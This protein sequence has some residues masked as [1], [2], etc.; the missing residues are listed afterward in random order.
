MFGIGKKR[1]KSKFEFNSDHELAEEHTLIKRYLAEAFERTNRYYVEVPFKDT[2]AGV[3]IAK[4][5]PELLCNLVMAAY[6]RI[7]CTE[8]AYRQLQEQRA[9]YSTAEPVY[10]TRSALFYMQRTLLRRKLPFTGLQL[11]VLLS[12]LDDTLDHESSYY[13]FPASGIIK[14]LKDFVERG[15]D[16]SE[17]VES[18][19]SI[20]RKA[21]KSPIRDVQKFADRVLTIIG[22]A[23]ELP[24]RAGE[25]WADAAFEYVE[26]AAKDDKANWGALLGHCSKV[27]GGKPNKKWTND[28]ERLAN[29]VTTDSIAKV[30]PDWFLLVDRP[31]TQP[32]REWSQWAPDPNLLIDDANADVL[33]GLAWV[34]GIVGDD[35]LAD[36][37][38][39]L[40][41]SAYR[42]VPGVGPRATKVG[43]ACVWAL[44][45]IP[46][47]S[48]LAALAILKVRVKYKPAQ[49]GIA[50]ALAAAAERAG[51]TPEELEEIGVPAYGMEQVGVRRETL[52]EYEAILQVINAKK[53]SLTWEN[54]AGKTIKTVPK[55]VR[56]NHAEELKDL[57]QASKDISKMLSA[58]RDRLDGLFL[59]ERSWK[60]KDWLERYIQHPLVGTLGQRLI[61]KFEGIDDN[62]SGLWFDGRV[63]G[64]DG[65]ELSDA[66]ASS[67]VSL[68][69]PVG[70]D[71]DTVVAWRS[72]IEA[73][74]ITQP[75]KQAHREIYLLTEAEE[76][77]GVYSNRYASHIVKQ[78]QFNALCAAR[79]WRHS[80]R[81]MVDD[82]YEPPTKALPQLGLRVEFWV[83]GIGDNYETD[84]TESGSFLYLATDQVRFY[85]EEA[86]PNSAHAAGGGYS[87][88]AAENET[89]TPIPL[90]DVDPLAL[91]EVLR[92]VDLFVG[93]A[94]VG[95]D[96]NWSDGGPEGRFVDYWNSYSFG[97]LNESAKTRKAILESLIPRLKIR[98][99]CEVFD[100]FLRVKGDIKTYKIHL[101]SGNVLMEPNDQYLCIVAAQG[102]TSRTDSIFLPFEGDNRMAV[103]LSKAFLLAEDT[104]IKD[105]TIL[106][107]IG[108]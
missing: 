67:A 69:H 39:A 105:R 90:R 70:E 80:L 63:I 100:R 65:S 44:G 102:K 92:D 14:A 84:A 17:L 29:A 42:K 2:T 46:G 9:G 76:N 75:F 103:I 61:W 74:E 18:A 27:S 101:G 45:Q 23:P 96:P 55:A 106:S 94:S 19:E 31:R 52:G 20:V 107:Q 88:Y 72:W 82:T 48:S 35:R 10:R 77:T 58:Q 38:G 53:V 62:T 51:M 71:V 26:N 22:M 56:E 95:N 4:S 78:H 104:K 33:K 11:Q 60:F 79:G 32:I 68:W 1:E 8:N 59:D 37:I 28:A 3:E 98:D 12:W 43:N 21:A 5:S 86:A 25:A 40:A 30:V 57:R 89:N 91:S 83:E 49:K 15:E 93:V 7:G 34:C 66:S 36:S 6:E 13:M 81:L 47:E 73:N 87:M 64:P 108:K 97:E 85:R 16:F 99:R 54:S 41:L 24:I 50:A